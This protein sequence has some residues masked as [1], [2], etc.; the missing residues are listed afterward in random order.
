MLECLVRGDFYILCPDNEVPRATGRE[1]HGL[2]DRR[3]HR[4][5]PCLCRAGIRTTQ[6]PLP[7]FIGRLGSSGRPSRARFFE[8][9]IFVAHSCGAW[10]PAGRRCLGGHW[11]RRYSTSISPISADALLAQQRELFALGQLSP[12]R[13][14]CAIVPS[15]M[16]SIG[17]PSIL[18]S[19]V[20]FCWIMNPVALCS[21]MTTVMTRMPCSSPTSG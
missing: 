7:A 8:P 13:A 11:S 14:S 21:R 18:F 9:G 20:V 1:T 16:T 4:E 10:R 3:H 2:G 5:P 15:S 6:M 12:D 17:P 19:S